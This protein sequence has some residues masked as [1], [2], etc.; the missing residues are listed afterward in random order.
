MSRFTGTGCLPTWEPSICIRLVGLQ[1]AQVEV[2]NPMQE[3]GVSRNKPPVIHTGL[4]RSKAL[5]AST[6]SETGLLA[7]WS[8]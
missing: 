4:T 1:G 5:E 3:V 8:R 7:F 2:D 6:W